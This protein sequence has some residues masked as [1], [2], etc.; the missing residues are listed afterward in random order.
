MNMIFNV[1]LAKIKI[2][3]FI[4]RAVKSD[5]KCF[6]IHDLFMCNLYFKLLL[7]ELSASHK[8]GYIEMVHVTALIGRMPAVI[9]LVHL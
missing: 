6:Y 3:V 2:V 8:A 7:F 1:G 9:C 4:Y 5:L